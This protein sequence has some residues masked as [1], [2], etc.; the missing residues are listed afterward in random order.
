MLK[1]KITYKKYTVE[2]KVLHNPELLEE[3]GVESSTRLQELVGAY[4]ELYKYKQ[5][6]YG[7]MINF[8]ELDIKL[9]A[10]AEEIR[11]IISE[12]G[13]RDGKSVL[14]KEYT[15]NFWGYALASRLDLVLQAD[16]ENDMY[17]LDTDGRAQTFAHQGRMFTINP[18]NVRVETHVDTTH[19]KQMPFPVNKE[20]PAMLGT[21]FNFVMGISGS[22]NIPTNE[23]ITNDTIDKSIK[24]KANYEMLKAVFGETNI[25]L[26]VEDDDYIE[27]EWSIK[28]RSNAFDVKK[29]ILK[30]K[31]IDIHMVDDGQPDVKRLPW[32]NSTDTVIFKTARLSDKFEPKVEEPDNFD[33]NFEF[34]TKEEGAFY[35]TLEEVQR[36]YPNKDFSWIEK[37]DYHM[38][39]DENVEEI[40]EY[41]L[42]FPYLAADTETTGLNITYLSMDGVQKPKGDQCVGYVFSGKVGQSYFYPLKMNTVP[43]LAGGDHFL[44]FDKY[45]RPLLRKQTIYHNAQFD[46]KV[47]FIYK[48]PTNLKLDTLVAF[49]DTY[50]Y[51]RKMEVGL[52][53]LTKQILGRD[54]IEISDLSR[55]GR[56]DDN[57]FADVPPELV[58]AY[59]CPDADNTLMLYE[60]LVNNNIL[61]NYNAVQVVDID[62]NFSLAIAYQEFWGM[63]IDVDSM[64]ELK[65]RLA[66]DCQD[67]ADIMMEVMK[68][69]SAEMVAEGKGEIPEIAN[70]NPNSTQQM[71]KIAYEHL[72]IPTKFKKDK[73]KGIDKATLDKGARKSLLKELK[74]GSREYNFVK[75]FRDY[76]DSNNLVKNF[77]KNLNTIMTEDGITFSEINQFLETGRLSTSKPAYQNYSDG[78]KLYITG[79]PGYGISDNDFQ[80]IE[81]KVIAG[82]SGDK[83]LNKAF[84]DPNTDYHKLQAANMHNIPYE[85]VTGAM[86]QDAKTF[87]FGIPFGMGPEALGELL[88]GK[89]TREAAEYAKIMIRKYF[90]GQEDV[91]NF[92]EVTRA[93]AVRDGYSSTYFGRRRYYDKKVKSVGSIRRAA[94]NQPIQGTAADSF[95]IAA[96]NIYTRIIKE[97]WFGLVLIPGFIH[98]EMLFEVHNSIHPFEWLKVVK[99]E[100]E[101]RF[102]GFPP[103]YLGWGYGRTWY[104]AKKIEIVTELQIRT[105]ARDPWE[106]YPD[107][108]GDSQKFNDWLHTYIADFEI[109]KVKEFLLDEKNDGALMDAVAW[110]Y[111]TPHIDKSLGKAPLQEQ[112]SAFSVKYEID[113]KNKIKDPA[114]LAKEQKGSDANNDT[115]T[116]EEF[117]A[118]GYADA[119]S[120]DYADNYANSLN[121]T[122]PAAELANFINKIDIYGMYLNYDN[123][124]IIFKK[125]RT[126]VNLIIKYREK[127]TEELLAT[128]Q[129]WKVSL[130]DDKKGAVE[131]TTV[132]ISN[133]NRVIIDK[134]W[135]N[136]N[137]EAIN[138][139][140]MEK[141]Y[142]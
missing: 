86:R 14:L 139:D 97:G 25:P 55:T 90:K 91:E 27:A 61:E 112:I 88:T 98:D 33:F 94:G 84:L 48:Q 8:E 83:R 59:A 44:A 99:E 42:S 89:R 78:V 52:K 136:Y 2:P 71:L 5:N 77:T 121:D 26:Y 80:S 130:Y 19:P 67:N 50:G 63:H 29:F 54:S 37:Q 4:N 43:N 13:I 137:I 111:M 16:T 110:G 75:A 101:L 51:E 9:N 35:N 100:A 56:Y 105:L 32:V 68:E 69:R 127:C 64:P 6:S 95:K 115:P 39:T 140:L 109:D 114:D 138:K 132:C 102:E 3:L 11:E 85:L 47:A 31:Y 87:N 116:F 92:F 129:Y 41:L 142:Q 66:K 119:D 134:V 62:S 106:V 53:S 76:T 141:A 30:S 49:K 38:V 82:L 96:T 28:R 46:A 12:N 117:V 10:L 58:V 128:G 118:S 120:I 131:E 73:K 60:Y 72:G 108:D 133:R 107:W 40:T 125:D 23:V 104:Q 79:R 65:A 126:L 113:V 45:I 135:R 93:N 74:E 20:V 123:K 124:E 70:F 17:F 36:R 15:Y 57:N 21:Y 1:G 81:Y 122:T 18:T 7:L 24:V 22:S 34:T 103:F